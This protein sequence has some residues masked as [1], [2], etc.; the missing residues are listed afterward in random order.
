MPRKTLLITGASTGIGAACARL[1]APTHD[2][3]LGFRS[4]TA[5]ATEVAD[6]ARA[7]GARVELLQADLSIPGEV[8]RMFAEF[9]AAFPR[10]DGLVNNAGIVDQAA[11]LDEIDPLRLRRM[12]DTNLIGPL[13]VAGQA[14]RRM[15]TRYGH[16]GGVIVNISSV[17]ARLG[18][19]GQYV[20]YAATK[21]ALD[22]MTRGL[23]DEVARESIRV[24]GIRPGIIET[25]IHGKG[26]QPD[27][28]AR[29]AALVPMQRAGTASEVAE[30]VLWL[31]S[32]AASYVT[33]A[34]LDVTGGR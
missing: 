17:A 25:P 19:P 13:L 11:R 16:A 23:A 28:A 4:D 6:Q 3:A 34:T 27:R 20:D 12:V 32:D 24:C 14:V 30:A 7:A 2:L 29:M 15:S 26:G 1:A 21:G 10:L 5:A 9:D 18:G 8:E 33:G 22:T 31:L